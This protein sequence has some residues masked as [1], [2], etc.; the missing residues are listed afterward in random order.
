[1][2]DRKAARA[3]ATQAS[4]H[5]ATKRLGLQALAALDLLDVYGHALQRVSDALDLGV[6]GPDVRQLIRGLLEGPQ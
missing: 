1:M 5:A 4:K 2:L 6:V 3:Y